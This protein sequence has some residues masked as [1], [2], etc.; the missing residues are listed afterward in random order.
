MLKNDLV[1]RL[2]SVNDVTYC[3]TDVSH[4]VWK[5]YWSNDFEAKEPYNIKIQLRKII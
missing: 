2:F 1:G 5:W 3:V 4:H